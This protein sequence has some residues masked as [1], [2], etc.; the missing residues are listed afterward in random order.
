[1]HNPLWEDYRKPGPNP[2][3]S[4]I[5]RGHLRSALVSQVLLPTPPTPRMAL[6]QRGPQRFSSTFHLALVSPSTAP[7]SNRKL[8]RNSLVRERKMP[9]DIQLNSSWA[10]CFRGQDEMFLEEAGQIHKMQGHGEELQRVGAI[11]SSF[12]K[13]SANNKDLFLTTTLYRTLH[14]R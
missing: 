7:V 1:M 4:I 13:E 3:D 12:P 9:R 6:P 5:W 8:S 14:G 10:R 11:L 2:F